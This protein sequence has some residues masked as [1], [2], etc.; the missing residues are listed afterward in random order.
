MRS[1]PMFLGALIDLSV[2]LNRIQEFLIIEE[3]NPSQIKQISQ[4]ST[5]DSVVIQP[6]SNFHWGSTIKKKEE[7]K[8][9]KN[10]TI[11]ETNESLLDESI[12]SKSFE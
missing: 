3:I 8:V 12:E 4:E 6:G 11:D 10:K 9:D 2:S 1:L 5:Q 7:K